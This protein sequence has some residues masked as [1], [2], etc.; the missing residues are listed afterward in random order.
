MVLTGLA[1]IVSAISRNARG[2]PVKSLP[3]NE[4]MADAVIK[5]ALLSLFLDLIF[6]PVCPQGQYEKQ[7]SLSMNLRVTAVTLKKFTGAPIT[8]PSHSFHSPR[9]ALKSSE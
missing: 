5:T 4:G 7:A 2:A 6:G 3:M 8:N 9:M 1:P